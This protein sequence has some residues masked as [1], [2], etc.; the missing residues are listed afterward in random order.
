[1]APPLLPTLY[2]IKPPTHIRNNAGRPD[3]AGAG[4]ARGAEGDEVPDPDALGPGLRDAPG[5]GEQ[6]FVVMAVV[7]QVT[8]GR[9][10]RG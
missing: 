6:R 3:G 4:Q 2:H 7:A 10:G 8:R 1:M 5:R 9:E